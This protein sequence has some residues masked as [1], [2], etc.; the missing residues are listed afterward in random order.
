[1]VDKL[2]PQYFRLLELFGFGFQ[3]DDEIGGKSTSVDHGLQVDKISSAYIK[4]LELGV[5]LIYDL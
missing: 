2:K 1:M 5:Y 4:Q 3:K